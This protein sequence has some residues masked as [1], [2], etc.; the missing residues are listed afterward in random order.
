MRT[1]LFFLNNSPRLY[2][3]M[4]NLCKLEN[5]W[6][7]LGLLFLSFS[8]DPLLFLDF[9][10][11]FYFFFF[12]FLLKTKKQNGV[13]GFFKTNSNQKCLKN[14]NEFFFS[15][16]KTIFFDFMGEIQKKTK[17]RR[18]PKKRQSFHRS[19]QKKSNKQNGV[20]GWQKKIKIKIPFLSI[21]A[22]SCLQYKSS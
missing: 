1:F 22:K 20:D 10:G 12:F 2:C 7:A 3:F 19:N 17:E 16:E 21:I 18:P 8:A 6:R 9:L 15:L 14:G 5:K 4:M 11:S 13:D